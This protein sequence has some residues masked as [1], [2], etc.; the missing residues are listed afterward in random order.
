EAAS[1]TTAASAHRRIRLAARNV[2]PPGD[3]EGTPRIRAARRGRPLGR[4]VAVHTTVQALSFVST[5]LFAG[6]AAIAVVQWVRRRD[7]A[8]GW[9]ALTFLS[10]GLIVTAGR[11]VPSHPHGFGPG[12]AQR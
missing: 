3:G 6:L 4:R 12:L 9:V 10:L 5:I 1:R 8:A 2:A 11:L 7:A